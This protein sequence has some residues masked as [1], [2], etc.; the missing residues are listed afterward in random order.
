MLCVCVGV[1]VDAKLEEGERLLTLYIQQLHRSIATREA[2]RMQGDDVMTAGM[3]D[4]ISSPDKRQRESSAISRFSLD[5]WYSRS[6]STKAF[7]IFLSGYW[8]PR[9]GDIR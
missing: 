7:M 2:R 3:E 5:V 1:C 6:S 8:L 4:M 9:L